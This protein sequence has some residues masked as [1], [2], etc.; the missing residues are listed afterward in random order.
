M[1]WLRGTFEEANRKSIELTNLEMKR[2]PVAGE[3]GWED[4]F[5]VKIRLKSWSHSIR[6][7]Q[8]TEWNKGI[9]KIKLTGG[10]R[11]E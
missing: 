4:K 7:N 10:W 6:Q 5:D 9:E 1:K 11:P 3:E 2:V 8:F